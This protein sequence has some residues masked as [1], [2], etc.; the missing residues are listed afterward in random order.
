MFSDAPAATTPGYVLHSPKAGPAAARTWARRQGETGGAA[1]ANRAR[2]RASVTPT[3]ARSDP[4]SRDR[5]CPWERPFNGSAPSSEPSA[6]PRARAEHRKRDDRRE[7]ASE[8]RYVV[9]LAVWAIE[10][11]SG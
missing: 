10:A 7:A 3:A 8:L 5:G 6:A 11:R 1:K 9:E 4:A 2:P